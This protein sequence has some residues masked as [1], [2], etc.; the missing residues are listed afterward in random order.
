M[1][2]QVTNDVFVL[3]KVIDPLGQL[4]VTACKDHCFRTCC[5]SVPTFQIQKNKTTENNVRYWRD[6]ES[7]RGDH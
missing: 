7:G 4:K 6:Y 1:K 3:K 2:T 5:P